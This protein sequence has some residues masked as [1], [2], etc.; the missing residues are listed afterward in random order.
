MNILNNKNYLHNKYKE[1]E[2]KIDR[3]PISQSKDSLCDI[4]GL[5]T[6]SKTKNT[7]KTL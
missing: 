4:E 6:K 5:M 2:F 1:F 7:K 3:V